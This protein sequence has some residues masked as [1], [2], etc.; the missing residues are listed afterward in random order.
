[1]ATIRRLTPVP[2]NMPFQPLADVQAAFWDAGHMLGSASV[3]IDV[4]E[5]GQHR[6]LVFSGDIGHSGAPILRDPH[7]VPEANLVI[8]ESTYGDR[9]HA[10]RS[11]VREL[12]RTTIE[13]TAA[14]NGK[15]IIPAF[16]VGRT[17][18]IVYHLNQLWHAGTLPPLPV[19]VDSP[20]AIDATD[21]FRTH[22]ECYDDDLVDTLLSDDDPFGFRHLHYVRHAS[23]SKKLNRSDQPAIIITA[24]GMCEGGVSCTT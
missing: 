13:R 10:E 20:M 4:H 21:I 5:S 17:Q 1:M 16:A 9:V 7:V 23:E 24:S 22:P 18:E 2:Y 6:R 15:L 12:L 11:Q 8:M 19:F 14:E 3:G